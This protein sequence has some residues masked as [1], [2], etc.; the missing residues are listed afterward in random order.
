MGEQALLLPHID[1]KRG[2]PEVTPRLAALGK[3]VAELR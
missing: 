3:R 2:E 1:D